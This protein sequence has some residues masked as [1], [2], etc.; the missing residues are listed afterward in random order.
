VH[1]FLNERYWSVGPATFVLSLSVVLYAV[2]FVFWVGSNVAKKNRMIPVFFL[3]AS[4]VNIALNFVVVP[5]YG[6]WGAAWTH[7]IGYAILVVTVYFY[8]QHWYAIRYEWRRLITL[9]VAGGATLG[10]VWALAWATGQS[11][12]MP[13]DE[14]LVRQLAAVP[15]L[16][17]FPLVLWA[18]RFW[19]PGEARGL[20]KAAAR[21]PGLGGL[22]PAVA[23]V[24]TGAGGTPAGPVA[25][26]SNVAIGA[27]DPA[28]VLAG[29]VADG[30]PGDDRE[31]RLTA[32]DA[33]AEDEETELEA[34][35]QLNV[36]EGGDTLG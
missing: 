17:I 35:A 24:A 21:L 4:G 1:L 22:A 23:D 26:A 7:V 11:V 13:L 5:E 32:D 19:T 16:L 34:N 30:A 27:D 36:T 3:I 12:D 28:A 29:A 25:E 20:R 10:A 33:A 2:Y 18:L 6:M 9:V 31:D 8:S 15:L 14:L